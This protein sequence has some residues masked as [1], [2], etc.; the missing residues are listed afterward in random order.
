MKRDYFYIAGIAILILLMLI[1]ECSQRKAHKTEVRQIQNS[2][3][4]FLQDTLKKVTSKKDTFFV[5]IVNE[6]SPE[7][8]MK[9]DVYGEL[10]YEQQLLLA[11][12]AR[13]KNLVASYQTNYTGQ[14][15]DTVTMVVR[16]P[17]LKPFYLS[18]L[19]TAGGYTYFDTVYIDSN[20][21]RRVH[22]PQLNFTHD[23]RITKNRKGE[24]QGE[25][26]VRGLEEFSLVA[27]N[28]YSFY[29]QAS[30]ADIRKRKMLK[31]LKIT[32]TVLFGSGMFYLGTQVN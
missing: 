9:S 21:V 27:N 6:L 20:L 5:G 17:V 4:A 22:L 12:L 30:P 10:K 26:R 14:K 3:A 25:I 32:G 8:I 16:I 29:S 2:A 13:Y 11:D 1:R 18:F 23:V 19:D 7:E 28:V 24:V 15:T 31:G